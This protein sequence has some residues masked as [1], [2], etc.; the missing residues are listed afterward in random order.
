MKDHRLLFLVALSLWAISSPAIAQV[1]PGGSIGD[2]AIYRSVSN[3]GETLPAG[4]GS[5]NGPEVPLDWDDESTITNGATYELNPSGSDATEIALSAGRHFVYY[6]IEFVDEPGTNRAEVQCKLNLNGTDLAIGAG[7]GFIRDNSGADECIVSGAAIIDVAADDHVLKLIAYRSD[8]NNQTVTRVNGKSAIQLIKL[9]DSWDYLNLEKTADD[10]TALSGSFSPV[11]WDATNANTGVAF[12]YTD[13]SANITLEQTGLYWVVANTAVER[14]SGADRFVLRQQISVG[15]SA[16]TG[17]ETTSYLRGDQNDE[18]AYDGVASIGTIVENTVAGQALNI[19][20]ARE[21]GSVNGYVQGGTDKGPRSAITIVRLPD[22]AE[23]LSLTDDSGQEI[24][25]AS[26]AI[27]WDTVVQADSPFATTTVGTDGK[28][29]IDTGFGDDYLFLGTVFNTGDGDLGSN[30]SNANYRVI[31][32]QGWQIDGSGGLLEYG[33]GAQ[34]NRDS[35][36]AQT[37]SSWSGAVLTLAESQTVQLVTQQR[38]SNDAS[39]AGPM[40]LQAL[41][42]GSV[43]PSTSPTITTN[44]IVGLTVNEVG[45]I[46]DAELFTTDIDTTDPN[47]IYTLDSDPTGGTLENTENPGIP[48]LTNDTFTQQDLI[49]GKIEFTAGASELDP[50]GFAFTVSD[51]SDSD[52]GTFVIRVIQAIVLTADTGTTDEDTVAN[53]VNTSSSSVLANDTGNSLTVTAYD[54]FSSNGAYVTMNPDGTFTYNPTDRIAYQV[55]G[56][57]DQIT[58]DSFTYTVTDTIGKTAVGTVTFTVNGVE[59][60]IHA[61]DDDGGTVTESTTI[62]VTNLDVL[63]NDGLAGDNSGNELILNY[64]AANS[65]GTGVWENLGDRGGSDVDWILTDVTRDTSPGSSRSKITAAYVWD[66]ILDRAVYDA[67]DGDSVNDLVSG[68]PDADDA[69][70]EYWVKPASGWDSAVMTIFETGGATGFGVVLDNGILKAA[71]EQDGNSATGSTVTYDLVNDPLDA[72]AGAA[73]VAQVEA[74][75][76]QF[77]VVI[78]NN[79]G[80]DDGGLT[81]YVNGVQVDQSFGGVGPDWDGGDGSGLGYFGGG[82]HGG[83]TNSAAG[84]KW[85]APFLGSIA[86]VRLYANQLTPQEVISTYDYV[87]TGPDVEGDSFAVQGILDNTSTLQSS[88]NH[89]IASGAKVTIT[90]TGSDLSFTYD[91]S[92]IP[93]IADLRY[94]ESTISPVTYQMTDA[95]GATAT[96]KVEFL[97]LGTNQANDDTIEATELVST[98]YPANRVGG[99]DDYSIGS[100]DPFLRLNA[101]DTTATTVRLNYDSQTVALPYDGGTGDFTV[102]LVVTGTTSTASGTIASIDGTTAS[103][104][105]NLTGVTGTFQ[106]D[107]EIT[108]TSTG[109]AAVNGSQSDNAFTLGEVV[110]GGSSGA[111]GTIAEVNGG[112][113]ILTTTSGTFTDNEP[114]TDPLGGDA[115]AN[116]ASFA[117]WENEGSG[118]SSYDVTILGGSLKSAAADEVV[119]N[120]S[121]IGQAFEDINGELNNLTAIS[122][123]DTTIEIWFKPDPAGSGKQLLFETGGSGTGTSLAYDNSLG[124]VNFTIDGGDEVADQQ[125]QVQ[126]SGIDKNEFNQL[127]AVYD[128]DAINGNEDV[129]T[130]Y[131]NNDPTSFN[132]TPNAVS[133]L[134]NPTGVNN[135]SGSNGSGL[136]QVNGSVA[137]N[138]SGFSPFDGQIAIVRVYDRQLTVAEIEENFD[139]VAQPITAISPVPPT[140]TSLGAEVTLNADGSFTYD[141]SVAGFTDIPEGNVDVDTF[142]YSIDD[143]EGGTETATVT[144]NV[145]G[146]GN[147]LAV[148]D[149]VIVF[150]EDAATAFDP[151]ANDQGAGSA[152]VGI[153]EVVTSFSDNFTAGTVQGE[154]ADF[155]GSTGWRYLWNAPSDWDLLNAPASSDASDGAFGTAA[156]YE[157]L[158]WSGT[159]WRPDGD[160]TTNNND[161]AGFTNLAA[162]GSGHP[163]LGSTQAGTT[164]TPNNTARGPIAAYTVPSDGVYGIA[165]STITRPSGSGDSISVLVY[166][167]DTLQQTTVVAPGDTEGFDINFGEL[168]TGDDIYIAVSS[169]SNASNDG[170]NWDFDIVT[171]PLATSP[172]EATSIGTFTT[173]GS[174]ITYDPNGGFDNLAVGESVFESI[175]YTISD[176]VEGTST[177][178]FTVEIQGENDAPTTVADTYNADEDAGL[179]ITAGFGIA[180]NDTD[181]DTGETLTTEVLE[182]LEFGGIPTFVDGT[183]INTPISTEQGG[184]VVVQEDGSFVYTPPASFND[185]QLGESENDRFDYVAKDTNGLAAAGQAT[186]TITVNGNDAMTIASDGDVLEGSD[187]SFTLTAVPPL[188]SPVDVTLSYSGSATGGGTDYTE[189]TM[190]T[191]PAGGSHT[192][193]LPTFVDGEYEFAENVTVTI[194]NVDAIEPEIGSPASATAL[195]FD[196]GNSAPTSPQI[197]QTIIDNG[198]PVV[199]DNITV[200]DP[201]GVE[202]SSRVN[203]TAGALFAFTGDFDRTVFG[204]GRPDDDSAFDM[205]DATLGGSGLSDNAGF[206]IDID[207]TPT[208]ADLTGTVRI[209]EIGGSSNGSSILL[210]DGIPHLLSKAGGSP[211]D[212]PTD[213]TPGDPFFTD[214]DW[215]GD[216]TI[217]VPLATTALPADVAASLAVVFRINNDEVRYSVNG[218]SQST[219]AL[220]DQDSTD[221]NGDHTVNIGNDSGGIGGGNTV[222]GSP[223]NSATITGLENGSGAVHS[224]RFWNS[225]NFTTVGSPAGAAEVV[226]ATLTVQSGLSQGTLAVTGAGSAVVSG[227]GT[228]VV[229]IEG[230]PTDVTATLASLE[231]TP[232]V[233]VSYPVTIDILLEDDDSA[234]SSGAI[235]ILDTGPA[236]VY[237]DDSYTEAF[238]AVVTDADDGVAGDQAAQRGFNAFLDLP[239]ALAAVAPGGTVIVNDGSY[240]SIDLGA[241]APDVTLQLTG[242]GDSPGGSTVVLSSLSAAS[243]NGID[244][245]AETLVLGDDSGDDAINCAIVGV[246][247][248]LTKNGSDLLILREVNT[249]TG[250]T[251]VNA[252]TL[253][254]GYLGAEGLQGELAG[255]GPV[256]VAAGARLEF[257][258]DLDKSITQTG[259]ISGDGVVQTAD[260]GTVIFDGPTANTFTGGFELGD[261]TNSNWNGAVGSKH[262]FVVVNRNDHLGTGKIISRGSQLQAGVPGIVISNDIDVDGGGLRC[263]G[264]NNLELS[265]IITPLGSSPRGISNFGPDDEVLLTVSGTIVM[266]SG[267]N[268]DGNNGEDNRDILISANMTGPGAFQLAGSYDDGAVTLSGT[269]DYTG[270]TLLN[271]GTLVLNG[272]HM[273]GDTYTAT[274]GS[275]LAGMGSTDSVV[276]VD[277]NGT[278]SPGTSIGTLTTGDLTLNGILIQEVESDFSFDQVIVNGT[279]SIGATSVL[280]IVDLSSNAVSAPADL[281]IIANDD[282]DAVGGNASFGTIQVPA[283]YLGSGR[284]PQVRY[285]GGTGNDVEI[286]TD[287]VDLSII[288]QWRFDNFSGNP[289]NTGAGANLADSESGGPDGLNNLL[290]FAIGTNPAVSDNGSLSIDEA[291]DQVTFGTQITD[292]E[293]AVGVTPFAFTGQFAR[294]KDFA[295]A[296]L[297]YTPQF[298]DDP[299]GPWVDST[300]EPVVVEYDETSTPVES[301]DYEVVEVPYIQFLPNGQK[302]RFFRILITFDE[303]VISD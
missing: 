277:N 238:G 182:V 26:P 244:I 128:K 117:V 148:N 156:N 232:D 302:A 298:S 214:L 133:P 123:N 94:G 303:S 72:I 265:G 120:F 250:T 221:W 112:H 97:V 204:D 161:P 180:V 48:L 176:P 220:L 36:N 254:V 262:G 66:N 152:T 162:D 47:L 201:D 226:T 291:F 77:V 241:L 205:D 234:S 259:A 296:G 44:S 110:T 131:V 235:V 101:N 223:F 107:E 225:A 282:N 239:S 79:D 264:S 288:G 63:A 38:A 39:A 74:D 193:T 100:A 168:T 65:P 28:V 89:T 160:D 58:G 33:R 21:T 278:L 54:S 61:V 172:I 158:Q 40:A 95:G 32:E 229:S 255:D 237:V 18:N 92:T 268:I 189:T 27:T 188:A 219:A 109:V 96:G 19:E 261:G 80:A 231:F 70:W 290:E 170:F 173:D 75:F 243:T 50:G 56:S 274:A 1:T 251:T 280:D 52:S 175:T 31:P 212:A 78:D 198:S 236:T 256:I 141:A 136:G 17:T 179:S 181:P 83:F 297:T 210:V 186:V 273:G 102:G 142:T 118:G 86:I 71:T 81:L 114:I 42:L 184:S 187:L 111:S 196:S 211:G 6:N 125:L 108:D 213:T 199:I 129:L 295:A 190:V 285:D 13:G 116:G 10:T 29:T 292:I 252:G 93:G 192:F 200:L 85:D 228:D 263:G 154:T 174:T 146:V 104:T 294:R 153:Q 3:A 194:T 115:L 135:I 122:T 195:I 169:D 269:N 271:A 132:G 287:L 245:G 197:N 206:A 87:N 15:G 51:G 91:P 119:S 202:V 249:Y 233:G 144:V 191:F 46:T 7:Q 14:E 286:F 106:D 64:E 62:T 37:A 30:N 16:V 276:V 260:D 35:T 99:N 2:R 151:L 284:N 9:D 49:D 88:G 178:T 134:P 159:A 217:V 145:T 4:T 124:V 8:N 165:N 258:V 266:T 164:T 20:V 289:A 60:A 43:F 275:T 301:V 113:L 270:T 185:L 127:V 24:N 45:A 69:T 207:F 25:P 59:D 76:Q 279:V 105:L 130:L 227:S 183:G 34:Y 166:V 163:G 167:N 209:W 224:V 12:S 246:G 137:N 98:N 82:N 215:V 283:D 126:A 11:S 272:T 216:D 208:A 84:T 299:G 253:R 203:T 300:E 121:A 293:Y 242:S 218:A 90:G 247:G 157:L 281:S 41:R 55:L 22:S 57:G 222:G 177:A 5:G 139:V 68:A 53:Q 150:E 240:G 230:S 149:E 155:S 138:E 73:G 67:E 143:G 103:G 267:I 23:W 147:F 248:N 171:L 140:T 257:L